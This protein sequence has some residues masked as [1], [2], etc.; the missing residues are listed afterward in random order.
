MKRSLNPKRLSSFIVSDNRDIGWNNQLSICKTLIFITFVYYISF[1]P[2]FVYQFLIYFY[3]IQVN[4]PMYR[5]LKMFRNLGT[6]TDGLIFYKMS[7][8]LLLNVA[9]SLRFFI[10]NYCLQKFIM[11]HPFLSQLPT[12][13]F[14]SKT[15]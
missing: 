4:A 6:L 3:A 14:H 2:F 10:S 15:T 8:R 1:L 5:G 13:I 12:L 11:E 9:C 7:S